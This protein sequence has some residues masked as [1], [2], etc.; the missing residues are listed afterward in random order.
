MLSPQNQ[1]TLASLLFGLGS[2]ITI[3]GF[4]QEL[5]VLTDRLPEKWTLSSQLTLFIQAANV[6]PLIYAVGRSFKLCHTVSHGHDS[7]GVIVFNHMSMIIGVISCLSLIFWWDK[8]VYVLGGYRSL[9]VLV[10][11]FG[12]SLLD[13]TSS[14]CFL[15]FMARFR[16]RHL[17]PYLI[18]EG[19]SGFIPILVSLVQGSQEKER[20]CDNVMTNSTEYD[21]DVSIIDPLE[22]GVDKTELEKEEELLFGPSWFFVSLLMTL[23]IS[24]CS[25]FWL[26]FSRTA[27]YERID[28][29]H[30]CG[31]SI[32]MSDIN[33][34]KNE[35]VGQVVNVKDVENKEPQDTTNQEVI[36][37]REYW[38]LQ[39]IMVYACLS[40][41]GIFPGLQSYSARPYGAWAFHYSVIVTGLAYPVGASFAL[42]HP[43]QGSGKGSLWSFNWTMGW[44]IGGSLIS[45]Y[46]LICAIMSPFPLFLNSHPWGGILMVVSWFAYIGILSYVKTVVTVKVTRARGEEALFFVGVFTQIG[47]V[48]GA[49]FIFLAV[50]HLHWFKDSCLE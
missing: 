44:T 12:L 17:T 38:Y 47:S 33:G 8:T 34:N 4:W 10:S 39:M 30:D 18:G 1:V 41:F 31:Q 23:L 16:E 20:E 25:F 37:T 28:I 46:I 24:W 43:F 50:N 11:S 40:T 36:T 22:Y 21:L 27:Q 9:V 2:W 48:A 49:I 45:I 35:K 13:C 5:P 42:F 32:Q 7:H 19:L 29:L 6:G 15:V 3:T 26:L 14:V